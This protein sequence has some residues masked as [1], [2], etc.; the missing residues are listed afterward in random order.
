MSAFESDPQYFKDLTKLN[1]HDYGRDYGQGLCIPAGTKIYRYGPQI[2]DG[3]DLSSIARDC[4]E[5]GK[6]GLYFAIDP[7][8]SICIC[9]EEYGNMEYEYCSKITGRRNALLREY[10]EM[11]DEKIKNND[12][13]VVKLVKNFKIHN[14]GVF[15]IT[16]D[17]FVSNGKYASISRSHIDCNMSTVTAYNVDECMKK[18]TGIRNP[19]CCE[20]FLSQTELKHGHIKFLMCYEFT[21]NVRELCDFMCDYARINKQYP[22]DINIYIESNILKHR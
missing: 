17:I 4:P 7:I 10:D 9:M 13:D 5:S 19:E 22:M 21:V 2:C 3:H 16:E 1:E 14:I 15:M 12:P 8:L 18:Y 6:I 20:L 11:F